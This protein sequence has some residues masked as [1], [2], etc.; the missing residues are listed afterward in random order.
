M[1][2]LVVALAEHPASD[3]AALDFMVDLAVEAH[4]LARAVQPLLAWV[5]RAEPVPDLAPMRLVEVVAL[6]PLGR[7]AAAPQ[8]ALEATAPVHP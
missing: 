3:L 4:K 1:Q 2:P 7:L 6:G 5:M 8:E